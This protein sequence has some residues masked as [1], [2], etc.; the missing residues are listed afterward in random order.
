MKMKK[1]ILLL[2]FSI[3]SFA[4]VGIGTTTPHTSA[5]LDISST[6]KGFLPPRMTTA[7]MNAITSPATGL[8]VVCTDCSPKGIYTYNGASWRSNSASFQTVLVDCAVNGFVGLF[9]QGSALSEASFSVTITNNTINSVTISFAATDLVLSGITGITVGTPSGSPALTSGSITLVPGANVAVTYPLTGTPAASGELTGTWTKVPLNC[10]KVQPVLATASVVSLDCANATNSGTLTANSATSS[11]S[12]TIAYTGGNGGGYGNQSIAST[13]VTGITA[14]LNG[15]GLAVGSGSVTYTITGTPASDG[16]ASFTITLGGQTCTF[17]RPVIIP[18]SIASLECASATNNGTLTAYS[19]TSSV[20]ST[21]AYTGGNG[22]GYG[23]QNI[24]STG[25]TG[26]TATLNGGGLAVGSGSVTYTITG[27]PA[28]EGTASFAITLGGKTCTFTRPVILPVGV[29]STLDCAGATKNG[30]LTTY[31]SASGVSSVITYTGGNGGTYSAQS[32]ASTGVTGLIATLNGGVLAVGSGNITYTIT[33]TPASEGTASFAITLGGKTCTFTRPV[34]LPVGVVS[35]LDCAGATNNGTLTTYSSASGVSSVITYTG[36]NGGTYSAQ[37]IASTG[38]TGLTATLNGGALAVSSGNI[39]YTITGTPAS[40][41]T[42]SFAITLGGKT[43]T[44]TRLVI[45]P[46]GVV[47]TLNCA[48]ATTSGDLLANQAASGATAVLPY[49]GGNGGIYSAQNITSTGVTGLTATLNAGILAVGSGSL[50]FTITG[51]PSAW[52]IANFAITL[53]GQT[54]TFTKSVGILDRAYG[55]TIFGANNHNF[56][57]SSVIGADGKTWLNNN[58]G[59]HYAD[60]NHPNFNPIQQATSVFDYLAY[61]SK[62]Q[63]GRGADGH[64]LITFTDSYTGSPVVNSTTATRPEADTAASAS[65]ITRD[66]G[67][68]DWRSATQ[69]YSLWQGV[70]GTNNP[71]PTG[72]RVPTEAEFTTLVTA[73]NITNRYSASISTLKFPAPGFRKYNDGLSTGLGNNCSYWTSSAPGTFVSYRYF[74]STS[75]GS[76][77]TFRAYGMSIRCIK[78]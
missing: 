8:L 68:N 66:D 3:A 61:G 57:Y 42:A 35:T 75:T 20:S 28:S 29:V 32:I 50:T 24:A 44:F 41:G 17:T 40:G 56:I 48:G 23:N 34:I 4:Q 51:N 2:L 1:T 36:G 11:V 38:V 47:S 53:G 78:N 76:I 46:V 22:G 71:C 13:G 37:S 39:T 49:S 65:F 67:V 58:L 26:L 12:S 15:G 74:Y 10:T 30:T 14:T 18:A 62:F 6:T 70:N 5:L 77:T 60:I 45:L 73:A 19:T 69:S 43:C 59:A 31:S 7:Q 55:Q 64:E 54:C 33:G 9:H 16:T 25:V 27:T 72:Y 52:G 63:W 21:I